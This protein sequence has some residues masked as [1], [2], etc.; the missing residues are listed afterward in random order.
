MVTLRQFETNGLL[1]QLTGNAVRESVRNIVGVQFRNIATVGGSVYGRFGFSD[2]ITVL[3]AMNSR[4]VMYKEGE[5]PLKD[6]AA[7]KR[8][9]DILVKII[10]P[11]ADCN[12]VYQSMRHTK[13]DFPVLTCCA[14]RNSMG[15]GCVIGARPGTARV[16]ADQE[17]ILA[18]GLTEDRI[19]AFAEYV[20]GNT[21]FGSNLRGSSEYRAR[22]CRTL[23]KRTLTAL[24]K[25][26]TSC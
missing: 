18:A 7:M 5:I 6:F 15:T 23:V 17:N 4:V 1:N 19:K 2:V 16:A 13:T 10:V 8:T 3:M 22:I 9:R 24:E 20:S 26:E 12:V 11:K 25:G 21:S 14:F